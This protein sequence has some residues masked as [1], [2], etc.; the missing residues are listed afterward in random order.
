MRLAD[1]ILGNVELIISEWETF[2]SSLESGATMT[3]PALRDHVQGILLTTVRDM[4]TSQSPVQQAKKSKGDSSTGGEEGELLDHASKQHG[5]ERMGSGFDIVEVVAEYRALRA[6]VFRLW[7]KSR[8]QTTQYDLDDITRFNESID[9]SLAVSVG[10]YTK[11]VEQSRRL[12]LAILGHDLRDPLNRIN[13]AAQ[14]ASRRTDEDPGSAKALSMMSMI[15]TDT[16]TVKQLV[17]DLIDF[18]SMGLGS[19]MP[20]TR[21]PVD[22]EKLCRNVFERVCFAHP[23]RTLRFHPDGDL[24]G[25][26]DAA[27]LQQVV[28][29]LMGNALQH[30]SP[31]GPIDLSVVSEGSIVVLSVRNEGS[32]IPSDMLAIIFDPLM[33]H[34]MPES[35]VRQ[36]SGSTGLGL[37]IVREIVIAHGGTVD[38]AST[39]AEGTVFTVRLPRAVPD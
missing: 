32:L 21:S 4:Q 30:G 20:L 35:T 12:F 17:N 1:F 26:W 8:S 29:N 6:S 15:K 31:E 22:L 34:T 3:K 37:Y 39:A 27:R 25:D 33:R 9:Q 7:H 14:L 19:A 38:V 28:S 16:Q 36:V 23:Q 11:H 5:L 13:L 24:T 2:A 10:S 18:A